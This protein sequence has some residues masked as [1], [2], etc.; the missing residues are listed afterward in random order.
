MR[1]SLEWLKEYV[2]L[3]G[4]APET[5][6]DALTDAGLEVESIEHIGG[7][8]SGVVVAKV[9]ETEKHPNADRLKLVTVN[10]GN[11]ES[12]VVCGA[13]N[14]QK[15]QYIAFAKVGAKVINRKDGS[16][17]ELTPAK[18]RG[19]ESKGMICAISELGLETF[20]SFE[21]DG[22][23][24]IDEYVSDADLGKDLKTALNL[25]ADVVLDT[26]PTANRGDLMSMVGVARE[27]AALFDRE[28]KLPQV[29]KS[30]QVP[31]A[32]FNIRLNDPTACR[33]FGGMTLEDVTVAP[34]PDWMIRRLEA[35]GVRAI[36]NVV[37]IT[38]YVLLELGQPLHGFD[39]DKLGLGGDINVRFAKE[40]EKFKTL[41]DEERTLTEKTAVVT[42]NDQPVALAGV[43]GG[44]STEVGD[45][46]T[47]VFLEGAYFPPACNRRSAKSVGLRSEASARFERGVDPEGPRRGIIRAAELLQKHAGAKITGFSESDPLPPNDLKVTLRF[48]QIQRIVGIPIEKDTAIKILKKLGFLFHPMKDSGSVQVT[49][50]SYRRDDVTREIDLIEEIIRIYGYDKVPYTMPKKSVGIVPSLRQTVLNRL[51]Q[52]MDGAGVQEVVTNSLIGE[53]LLEK[54][55]FSVD[56]SQLVCVNNS[57][58]QDHTLMRQSLLPTLIEIAKFNL[59]QGL[60]DVWI[61]E[62]GRTYFKK[63][64]SGPKASGVVEKLS[65]SGF[66]TGAIDEGRWHLTSEKKLAADFF[67]AKGLLE[68]LFTDLS[69]LAAVEFVPETENPVLHPGKSAAIKLVSEGKKDGKVLGMMGELHPS[70]QASL[71]FRQPVF[72]FELDLEGIISHLKNTKA[73]AQT[74]K[75]SPYPS[76]HRDMAFSAP[77]TLTHADIMKTLGQIQ[78]PL[79]RDVQ[80]FD[81]YKS[82]QLEKGHR[83]LA[84]RVTLQSDETTLT[85]ADIDKVVAKLR[86]KLTDDHK[87]K[88][89]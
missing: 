66:L 10:T 8:F 31:K 11:A 67:T 75:V 29:P 62:T 61:Y 23:W 25:Q 78:E 88:F 83:S 3:D 35:A 57:H 19:V 80:V 60:Q 54:T 77:T 13:P 84:Y 18:I 73:D 41:D 74:I 22:I 72:V 50:P 87:V 49:I 7:N 15:D 59:A 5:I 76:V 4:L 17:F 79:V 24:P 55:G 47:R 38:N 21:E 63:G 56:R 44:A 46:T 26:A 30:V 32:S 33:Y 68:R 51:H 37:D 34:S 64:K 36:S 81:E 89:R 2:D 1:V 27:V 20:Y 9:T 82:D 53:A 16:T 70:L 86:Q 85:D 71:K 58:S 42:L 12:K 40:N 6:A 69:M 43:M 45:T 39:K 48:A 65:L 14:V 52:V 28:L